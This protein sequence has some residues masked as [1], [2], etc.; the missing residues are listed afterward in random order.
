MA[1][2]Q[3]TGLGNTWEA[4][5]GHS[6]HREAVVKRNQAESEI[7]FLLFHSFFKKI[8]PRRLL[9]FNVGNL[10]FCQFAIRANCFKTELALTAFCQL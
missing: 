3:R 9:S 4:F 8:V 7:W 2:G 1:M 10:F 5:L 6:R